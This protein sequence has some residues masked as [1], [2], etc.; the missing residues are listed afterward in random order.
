VISFSTEVSSNKG[1]CLRRVARRTLYWSNESKWAGE[2]HNFVDKCIN[3]PNW[4][5]NGSVLVNGAQGLSS[6]ECILS[7]TML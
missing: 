3:G 4:C 2:C 5:A 7:E 6:P 1:T